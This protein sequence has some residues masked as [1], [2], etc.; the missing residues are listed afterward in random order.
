MSILKNFI[1]VITGVKT[2]TYYIPRGESIFKHIYIT[3]TLIKIYSLFTNV[4]LIMVNFL[5]IFVACKIDFWFLI[6]QMN[7]TAKG[8]KSIFAS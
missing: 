1:F 2:A 3:I 7:I 6:A 5:F 4:Y 8:E